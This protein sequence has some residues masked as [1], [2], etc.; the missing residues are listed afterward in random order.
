M[1][2]I[3]KGSCVT[4]EDGHR[5]KPREE[6]LK[7]GQ[8]RFAAH[9]RYGLHHGRPRTRYRGLGKVDLEHVLTAVALSI[10][11]VMEWLGG[12]PL[13]ERRVSAF[14][15]LPSMPRVVLR[16]WEHLEPNLAG[17]PVDRPT[18]FGGEG[19]RAGSPDGRAAS[20]RL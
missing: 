17:K 5:W 9:A 14:A 18:S 2:R 19:S 11:R 6:G 7:P 3:E 15:R 13:A 1:V 4:E 8:M 12:T 20:Q 10:L 16:A